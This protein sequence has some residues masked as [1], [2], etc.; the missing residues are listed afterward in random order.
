MAVIS[1]HAHPSE[2]SEELLIRPGD[3]MLVINPPDGYM[4]RLRPLPERA[5]VAIDGQTVCDLVQVF[6]HDRAEMESHA[7][8]ALDVL[9]PG[10]V[11]WMCYRNPDSLPEIPDLNRDHGWALLHEA[12]F[13]FVGP[14]GDY[15]FS[16]D[17][18][19]LEMYFGAAS[20]A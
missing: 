16:K 7:R 13:T 10:G 20:Q 17:P 2:L 8:R 15:W 1:Q 4:E 14:F 12:G 11:L 6:A 19:V 3:R 9:K 5:S 18:K